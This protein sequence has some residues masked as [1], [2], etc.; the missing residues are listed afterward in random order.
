MLGKN[1]T[2]FLSFCDLFSRLGDDRFQA[3]LL[4]FFQQ[5]VCK[6]WA[7]YELVLLDIVPKLSIKGLLMRMPYSEGVEELPGNTGWIEAIG[8]SIHHFSQALDGSDLD[9]SMDPSGDRFNDLPIIWAKLEILSSL[10]SRGKV[11]TQLADATANLMRILL[12][13]CTSTG[14]QCRY[15]ALYCKLLSVSCSLGLKVHEEE[16]W[17]FILGR[18]SVA[19]G[20]IPVL[21]GVNDFLYTYELYVCP[22]GA[23][24][25][26]SNFFVLSANHFQTLHKKASFMMHCLIY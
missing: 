18:S 20:L 21:K 19:A 2:F 9:L 12:R 1:G 26:N 23:M 22:M 8:V 16:A 25:L 14:Y 4:P 17:K 13:C 24:I 3:F 10:V 11:P 15:A 5:F 6:H 7:S